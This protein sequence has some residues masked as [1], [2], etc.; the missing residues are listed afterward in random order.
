MARRGFAPVVTVRLLTVAS[1]LSCHFASTGPGATCVAAICVH[2]SVPLY[3]MEVI[4]A[5]PGFCL[6]WPLLAECHTM[7]PLRSATKREFASGA[8]ATT[9]VATVKTIRRWGGVTADPSA[10]TRYTTRSTA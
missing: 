9:P 5:A 2:A 6:T 7:A 4:D 8:Q 3:V 10:G 1:T